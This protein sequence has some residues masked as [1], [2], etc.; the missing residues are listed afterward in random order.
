MLVLYQNVIKPTDDHLQV[1]VDLRYFNISLIFRS[2]ARNV[3]TNKYLPIER[4]LYTAM[5][6]TAVSNNPFLPIT[7]LFKISCCWPKTTVL[8]HKF[9]IKSRQQLKWHV[10]LLGKYL[11]KTR[12]KKKPWILAAYSFTAY[13]FK[14]IIYTI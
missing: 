8:P 5:H 3:S 10:L 12:R 14:Y 4:L 11:P 13:T 9:L 2:L 6:Q 1:S 7:E